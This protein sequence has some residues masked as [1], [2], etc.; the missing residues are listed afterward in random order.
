MPSLRETSVP[1]ALIA[2]GLA[3]LSAPVTE[4]WQALLLPRW[5]GIGTQLVG[6]LLAGLGVAYLETSGPPEPPQPGELQHPLDTAWGV[7]RYLALYLICFACVT[8]GV[9]LIVDTDHDLEGGALL[10]LGVAIIALW[11]VRL[12][13]EQEPR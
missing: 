2:L 1:L 11:R 13:R 8:F 4:P 5:V 7:I 3:T 10:A 6:L 9:G 12:R